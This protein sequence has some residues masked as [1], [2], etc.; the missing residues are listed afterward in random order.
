[1]AT[2]GTFVDDVSL[3]ANE[4]NDFLKRT[5]FTSVLTQGSV[6]SQQ[7][8]GQGF[9]FQVNKLVLCVVRCRPSTSGTLNQRI[10]VD[11]P[12]AAVSSSVRV[13]GG[14]YVYDSS[15]NDVTLLRVVQY[16]T[17]KVAFLTETTTSLT[18]YLG[19]SNGPALQIANNDDIFFHCVYAA[20]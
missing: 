19:Q 11:L 9:Y 14:G 8:Q 17:T 18:T 6:V 10:E 3:K 20:A 1:M 15:D 2:F 4:L 7:Q 16:S 13:I 5:T 12:V